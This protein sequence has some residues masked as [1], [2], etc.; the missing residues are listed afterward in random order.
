MNKQLIKDLEVRTN[1]VFISGEEMVGFLEEMYGT[2]KHIDT[3]YEE[4]KWNTEFSEYSL[5]AVKVLAL[6]EY[7]GM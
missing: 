3:I 4:L 6:R 5:K 1:M 2:N 7:A